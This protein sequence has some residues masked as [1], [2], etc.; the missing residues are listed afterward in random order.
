MLVLVMT[1]LPLLQIVELA[2]AWPSAV[3]LT[4][5]SRKMN[6]KKAPAMYYDRP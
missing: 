5:S 2:P 3:L 6:N 1:Y 4:G